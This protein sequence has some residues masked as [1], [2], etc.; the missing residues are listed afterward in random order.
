M[1]LFSKYIMSIPFLIPE[2]GSLSLSAQEH[3]NIIFIMTD[4][5]SSMPIEDAGSS[6]SRPVGFNGDKYVHTPII[7]ILSERFVIK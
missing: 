2:L 4:D 5:Q 3:P 1:N 6:Q 7:D